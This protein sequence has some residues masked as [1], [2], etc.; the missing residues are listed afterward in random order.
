MTPSAAPGVRQPIGGGGRG[1]RTRL[2]A[3]AKDWLKDI[4]QRG[5]AAWLF[6]QGLTLRIAVP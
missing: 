4:G 5:G 2:A 3:V 1:Q 6:R